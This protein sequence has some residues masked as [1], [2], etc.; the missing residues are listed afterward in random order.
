MSSTA[1]AGIVVA[2]RDATVIAALLLCT[3][4]VTGSIVLIF[5]MNQPITGF[6]KIS[7]APVR[8]AL[9]HLGQ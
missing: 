1:I 6:I 3:L 5:E 9:S 8:D 4:S 7:S 2:P